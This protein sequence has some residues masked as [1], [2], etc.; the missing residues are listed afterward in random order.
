M[1]DDLRR[2]INRAIRDRMTDGE[3]GGRPPEDPGWS[4]TGLCPKAQADGIPCPEVGRECD[5]CG[6]AAVP[7]CTSAHPGRRS[8]SQ[9]G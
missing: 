1:D 4:G 3:T 2:W 5:T 9:P 7:A 8:K 6:L